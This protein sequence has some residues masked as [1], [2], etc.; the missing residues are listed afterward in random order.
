[1][2]SLYSAVRTGALNKA[3]CASYLEGET[4]VKSLKWKQLTAE[5]W[6]DK[7]C[8]CSLIITVVLNI[9]TW[10]SEEQTACNALI[11]QL[12]A[13]YVDKQVNPYFHHCTMHIA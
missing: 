9:T 2:K 11:S 4:N 12:S 5:R 7:S 13:S 8:S 10:L 3:V 6:V 1:M